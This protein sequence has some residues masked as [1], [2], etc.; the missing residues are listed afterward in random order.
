[1]GTLISV[2]ARVS[3]R[4]LFASDW[5][6][7]CRSPVFVLSGGGN[8]GAL[9]V[10]MMYALVE[11]G[12]RP[13]MIV[14][15]SVGAI[16]G[17]FLASRTDLPGITEIAR[18]WLSLRRKDVL[19]VDLGT[20][21]GGLRRSPRH[22]FD[23]SPVRRILE[24][25]VGFRC[26]ED[27]PIP[28]AVVATDLESGEAV[29]LGSGDA[30]TALLASSAIP[31]I[32]PPVEMD[33]RLL[34]DG[35]A[36]ADVPLR[37]AL[38]LGARDL[39]VLPTSPAQVVSW[40]K[41]LGGEECRIVDRPGPACTEGGDGNDGNDADDTNPDGTDPDRS[42]LPLARIVPPPVVHVPLANLGQSPSMLRLGYERARTWLDEG[43]LSGS[44]TGVRERA[45][46]GDVAHPRRP[47][48]GVRGRS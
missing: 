41:P 4:R 24:S 21:V 42:D 45:M 8:L 36:V 38:S 17:A 29:I 35:A 15:T 25:F 6:E 34:V 33:G 14:G 30:T 1:V 48:V 27:S 2:D 9:Q 19:G 18:L 44:D 11:S 26:L 23:S 13:G 22:L 28:L 12:L 39:Y 5:G 20:L 3:T 7:P 31:G 37:Q 46:S 47:L 10:G 16:N 43:P 40:V 32:F